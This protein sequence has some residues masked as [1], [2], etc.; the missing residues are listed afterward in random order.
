MIDSARC[1]PIERGRRQVADILIGADRFS[2]VGW[3]ILGLIV[4]TGKARFPRFFYD[5]ATELVPLRKPLR[6]YRYICIWA[7]REYS[8]K[9]ISPFA[10]R[11]L[12]S[13]LE[14]FYTP[15][16]SMNAVAAVGYG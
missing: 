14:R 16:N 4:E 9:G 6:I 12:S 1:G 5:E 8:P 7:L 11:M 10:S 15:I 2:A 3:A 13:H